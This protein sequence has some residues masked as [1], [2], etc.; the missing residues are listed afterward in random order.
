MNKRFSIYSSS[1]FIILFFVLGCLFSCRSGSYQ[2]QANYQTEPLFLTSARISISH[3]N[4]TAGGG[5]QV[6]SEQVQYSTSNLVDDTQTSVSIDHQPARLDTNHVYALSGITVVSKARFAPVREG[7][8]NVEFAIHIPKQF[9]SDNYHICLTPELLHNDSLVLLDDVVLR[10]RNFIKKQE[11]DYQQYND[12]IASIIDPSGYDTAF[13]DRRAADKELERYRKNEVSAYYTRFSQY[14]EYLKWRDQQQAKYDAY[15]IQVATKLNSDLAAHAKT[16]H[17]RMV[18]HKAIGGDTVA[19]R[20]EFENERQKIIDASPVPRQIT[21]GVVP[22]KFHDFYLNSVE[23]EDIKPVLPSKADSMRI[24]SK[25]RLHD[26]IEMNKIK[27]SRREEAF[28]QMV[29]VPYHPNAH[30]STTISPEWNFNYAYATSYPVTSGL[31][32]L[33]LSLKSEFVAT[34]GSRYTGNQ[35]DTLSY[36]ISSMDELASRSLLDNPRFTDVQRK[37]YAQALDLLKSRD[38]KRALQLLNAYADY[39]TA[40][41]LTCLGY[42]EQAYDLLKQLRKNADTHYLMAI[43]CCRLMKEQEA[44]VELKTA[45]KLDESKWFRSDRDPEI[46]RLI[47]RY[48]LKLDN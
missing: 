8:V 1:Y 20:R 5:A 14:Q 9:L 41:A 34:D 17:N 26:Q 2:Q 47:K 15:N 12:Y 44:I 28:K 19:L 38:Y 4:T 24:A 7:H 6:L 45:C 35:T 16:Y 48:G 11:E 13:I 36:V 30:Y 21:L 25:Y 31:H 39:N 42:D 37:E 3:T 10:G 23:Q 22:E 33:R 27:D 46:S 32:T 18:R 43:L 40:L 29:P